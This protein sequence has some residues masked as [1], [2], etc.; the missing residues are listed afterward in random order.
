LNLEVL[1][2]ISTF[3]D[4]FLYELKKENVM[5][6]LLDENEIG[7]ML[8]EDTGGIASRAHYHV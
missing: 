3:A 2:Q 1:E 5:V 6:G 7:F 4:Q 8:K